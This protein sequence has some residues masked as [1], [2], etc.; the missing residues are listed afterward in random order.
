MSTAAQLRPIAAAP[1]ASHRIAEFVVG[2]DPGD[3]VRELAL[4]A[5]LDTLAVTIAGGAAE[6][7]L[8]LAGSLEPSSASFAVPSFWQPLAYRADDAALLFGMASHVLDYDDVSMLTVCHPTAPVLSACLA[9]PRRDQMSGVALLDAVSIGTEVMIRLGEVMGFRHYEL[10]FHATATLG[11]LGAAAA[12]A[13]L[14]RLDRRQTVQALSIAASLSSG[15]RKNFGSMVKSLHVGVAAANGL[16]AA[17]L[18]AAGIEA[19]PEALEQDGFL[20]AFSGGTVDSWPADHHLGAPYV[21]EAPGFERKRYPCCYMLHKM[22]EG[23]LLLV[24][25]K[26]PGLAE[27]KSVRVEMPQGGTSPLIHPY[28]KSGMNA[29]FSGPYA[30]IASLADGDITLKS[31]TDAEVL[32]PEIQARLRDV[33]LVEAATPIRDGDLG[34]APVT[35]TLEL[36]NGETLSRTIS[37]PPGSFRDPMTPDQL[38]RKWLD[39]LQRGAPHLDSSRAREL[40]ERGRRLASVS[41]VG[42]WLAALAPAA[43]AK[44]VA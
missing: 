23:T 42:P 39:C 43:S 2:A 32:R 20:K 16:K 14:L 17:R 11:P 5:V 29:L 21:L 35:V 3:A 28:P 25:E 34:N 27:V 13:R 6:G 18:A 15:L 41:S 31:F 10:G 8:R 26:H 30:V 22:I 1:P 24:R 44:D 38:A 4:S 36:R 40:F 9:L 37:D 33:R 19:S 12:C 7:V